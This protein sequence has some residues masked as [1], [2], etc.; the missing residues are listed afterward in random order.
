MWLG[1]RWGLGRVMRGVRTLLR[2]RSGAWGRARGVVKSKVQRKGLLG[3]GQ[4][5]VIFANKVEGFRGVYERGVRD[6]R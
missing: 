1:E 2:R 4:L 5:S 6:Q 3:V